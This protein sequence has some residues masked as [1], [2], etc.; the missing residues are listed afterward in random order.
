MRTSVSHG[1]WVI[2]SGLHQRAI[3]VDGR[4]PVWE[5]MDETSN[6]CSDNMN[7][8]IWLLR[9]DFV[10]DVI[11]YRPTVWRNKKSLLD[12]TRCST[13]IWNEMWWAVHLCLYGVRLCQ[14]L[15]KL[16][17]SWLSYNKYQKG[18]VFFWDTVYI[19]TIRYDTTYSLHWKTDRQAAS[20]IYHLN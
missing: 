17:N 5:L 14:E 2:W 15:A 8:T 13:N 4:A 3:G 19:H 7:A 11:A 12:S 10:F 18:D 1:C 16:Y 20:L 9:V 6:T